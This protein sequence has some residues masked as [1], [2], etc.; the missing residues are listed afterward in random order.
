MTDLDENLTPTA[1]TGT[2][3]GARTFAEPEEPAEDDDAT[4]FDPLAVLTITELDTGSRH[5]KASI[6]GAITGRT[7]KYETALAVVLWLHKRRQ[8]PAA[9]L[10][11]LLGLTF[12]EVD[13]QLAEFAP[14]EEGPT[15]P[16]HG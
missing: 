6:V 11:P 1:H 3:L 13:D 8:D 16:A 4:P 2:P 15:T 9:K 5:L 12:V 14:A 7:E 10:G